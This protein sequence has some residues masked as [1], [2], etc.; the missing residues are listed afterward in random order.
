MSSIFSLCGK[1][2]LLTW[3]AT[4]AILSIILKNKPL[5]NI[6][7][8]Y[9]FSSA[10]HLSKEIKVIFDTTPNSFRLIRKS[11]YES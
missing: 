11:F 1:K 7:L 3:R 4:A 6:A 2:Q 5:T 9:G 8:D 10:S